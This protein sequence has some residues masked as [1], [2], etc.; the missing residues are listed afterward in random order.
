MIKVGQS[1]KNAQGNMV[2]INSEGGQLFYWYYDYKHLVD[3]KGNTLNGNPDYSL[4]R[5]TQTGKGHLGVIQNA[6][7]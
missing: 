4:V 3:K 6:N 1:Y 5:P 2:T 7:A